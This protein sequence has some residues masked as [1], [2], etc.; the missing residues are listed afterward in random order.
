MEN[1]TFTFHQLI[2]YTELVMG[3]AEH[4]GSQEVYPPYEEF[5]EETFGDYSCLE[6]EWNE[7]DGLYAYERML[8]VYYYLATV[9]LTPDLEK[10][11]EEGKK[12]MEEFCQEEE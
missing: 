6:G 12:L 8:E 3:L 4:E 7:W 9:N 1:Y 2:T 10:W 11:I 5:L